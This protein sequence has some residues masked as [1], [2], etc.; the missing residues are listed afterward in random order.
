MTSQALLNTN[1]YSWLFCTPV[2]IV[3]ALQASRVHGPLPSQPLVHHGFQ[4]RLCQGIS[5]LPLACHTL[6]FL[7][8]SHPFLLLSRPPVFLICISYL[9]FLNLEVLCQATWWCGLVKLWTGWPHDYPYFSGAGQARSL[10][11]GP[12][13][14]QVSSPR[15]SRG[16]W[17]SCTTSAAPSFPSAFSGQFVCFPAQASLPTDQLHLSPHHPF[18]TAERCFTLPQQPGAER[19]GLLSPAWTCSVAPG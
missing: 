16:F 8:R 1:R 11:K 15:F 13:A 4:R 7:L 19:P 6:I 18:P 10:Q 17:P 14:W 12:W 2:S 5:P 3:L 9:H